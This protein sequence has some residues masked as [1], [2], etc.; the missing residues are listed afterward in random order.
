MQLLTIVS[1]FGSG[2]IAVFRMEIGM[3]SVLK[4]LILVLFLFSEITYSCHNKSDVEILGEADKEV[5][6][7]E[8]TQI[9]T[10]D[11]SLR[12]GYSVHAK[13]RMLERGITKNEVKGVLFHGIPHADPT[14]PR[15]IIFIEATRKNSLHVIMFNEPNTYGHY[16]V[17]TVYRS[18]YLYNSPS[19]EVRSQDKK[20]ALR[21]GKTIRK[22]ARTE[23]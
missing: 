18:D 20:R 22:G 3:H 8:S 15:V 9:K 12:E 13:E 16:I 19:R 21:S 7:E 17:K 2:I 10:W 23:R 11:K 5:T 6:A 1:C 4:S 14:N